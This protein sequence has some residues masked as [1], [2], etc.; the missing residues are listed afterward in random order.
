MQAIHG[1]VTDDNVVGQLDE[2]GR[3]RPDGVIDFGDLVRSWLVADLAVT[4][5]SVL[6]HRPDDPF[7]RACRRCARSTSVVPL[8]DADLA[9]LW[10]LIVLRGAVLVASGEHQAALDPDNESATEPLE[11]EWRIFHTA[12]SVPFDLAEATLRA[13]LGRRACAR[14]TPR[15]SRAVAGAGRCSPA[16][17][18]LAVVDLSATSDA[19]HAGRFLAAPASSATCCAPP[20]PT[21]AAATRHGEARLTRTRARLRRVAGDVRARRRPRCCRRHAG[22]RAVGRS[23]SPTVDGLDRRRSTARP[24]V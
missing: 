7:A 11:S 4:C 3:V 10:P 18:C 15:R 2:A 23:R 17:P 9:A 22:R 5:A 12:R 14:G 6:R 1:D 24:G 21:A 8:D 13:A 19:L 20:R 16:L